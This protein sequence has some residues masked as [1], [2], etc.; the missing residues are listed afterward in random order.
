VFHSSGLLWLDLG[1]RLAAIVL[2]LIV[3]C[4][5]TVS[6]A[7]REIYVP[8]SGIV[9]GTDGADAVQLRIRNN[10]DDDITCLASLAH[11]YSEKLGR[12]A[13][14]SSLETELW[15]DANTGVLNLLNATQNRMPIEAIWCGSA[16]AH[17]ATR[18]RIN[19]PHLA[20]N[21]PS[22]IIRNCAVRPDGRLTCDEMIK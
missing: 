13:P 12:A 10:G 21:V 20:G 19:L 8:Y 7:D 6:A 1:N 16:A 17:H 14:G 5:A 18:A 11:W 4:A 22:E 9:T 15:H 2:G 3:I